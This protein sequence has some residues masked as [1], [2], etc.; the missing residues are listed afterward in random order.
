[1][2]PAVQ[3][4]ESGSRVQAIRL[5]RMAMTLSVALMTCAWASVNSAT[6]QE[7]SEAAATGVMEATIE[8]ALHDAVR[9]TKIER[10]L[11]QI[12]SAKPVT[13]S[14]GSLGC[15]DEI[16]K[17]SQS[18]VPGF[19]IL[20]QAGTRQLEYHASADGGLVLCPPDRAMPPVAKD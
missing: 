15:P 20:I 5:R 16:T 18:P 6:P 8:A 10:S 9:E 2:T 13:W 11:L 17:Y 19:H 1:M 4:S 12:I 14:D 3:H 7:P